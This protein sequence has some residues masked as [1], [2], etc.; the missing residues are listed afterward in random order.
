MAALRGGM[1]LKESRRW[2]TEGKG[3]D[4]QLRGTGVC[5]KGQES[6]PGPWSDPPQTP[7][8]VAPLHWAL[9]GLGPSPAAK[10]PGGLGIL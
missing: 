8:T 2:N 10:A 7:Q 1:G 9:P 4:F 6:D 5:L 3:R